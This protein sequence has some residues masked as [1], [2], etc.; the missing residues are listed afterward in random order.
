MNEQKIAIIGC[1]AGGGTAAQFARKTDRKATITIYEQS[2]Y[3]QYS[4][5]GLPYVIAGKIPSVN[6]LLE[7]SQ[8]WFAKEHIT[9][10]LQTTVE[11][12][13]I[14]TKTLV[15]VQN[16]TPTPHSF[17]R[18]IIATGSRPQIPPIHGIPKEGPLPPH[19]YCLRSIDDAVK[20][21]DE[22][23]HAKRVCI[24]GAGF[25]GLELAEAFTERGLSVTVVEALPH[26]LA[27]S[28]DTDLCDEVAASFPS[29][30]TIRPNHF[31]VKISPAG[32]AITVQ[33]KDRATNK[34]S[35]FETDFVVLATGTRPEV[36]L[37][38]NLGCTIGVTGGI[39]VD[40]HART[41]L[42]DVYAVGDCTEYKDFVTGQ[43]VCAGLG[44]IAV[45]QGITSGINAAGG[46]YEMPKGVLLSRTSTFFGI[47]IAAV[48]PLLT[49]EYP[50]PLVHGKIA[51]SSLPTY[52]PGGKPIT[53]KVFA[54]EESGRIVAAQAIGSNASQRMN[55]FAAAILRG[56]TVEE[57]QK[58]ETT[59][60][61]PLAP[62]LD[63][64]TLAC[65]VAQLKRQRK[66]RV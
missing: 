46:N 15:A 39:L 34:E 3:A 12:I 36:H 45:R 64:I 9:V 59:Y 48:G 56:T 11:S 4:R 55:V 6:H 65:D 18:L 47:Q 25:I 10:H 17:D 62:T 13:D 44:T 16:G 21:Q 1:G 49:P 63:V 26:I 19:V 60:A 14:S 33:M 54:E 51:G 53:V 8:D 57:L 27:N 66:K 38:K 2:P 5:C 24:V 22:M 35:S 43:P 52:F 40:S 7:Y 42:P 23:R 31:V 50:R 41:S 29:E 37:A 28:L 30:V 32:K 58:L 61:P 20:I